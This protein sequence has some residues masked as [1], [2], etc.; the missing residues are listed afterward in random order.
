MYIKRSTSPNLRWEGMR[1][2][3]TKRKKTHPLLM[4]EK[5]IKIWNI[6]KREK[7]FLYD[8][9]TFRRA[10][11]SISKYIELNLIWTIKKTI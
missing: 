6:N 9:I 3:K 1:K 5:I 11:F 10:I 8:E 4:K 7:K 2:R